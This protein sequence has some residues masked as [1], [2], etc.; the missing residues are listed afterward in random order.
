MSTE[1][2]H[3]PDKQGNTQWSDR[4]CLE[5]LDAV[6]RQGLSRGEAARAMSLF[7][8]RKVSRA[9]VIG[10]LYRIEQAHGK[11]PC[12]CSKPENQDGG[13]PSRWWAS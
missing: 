10:L 7:L 4:E 5:M 2:Q 11:V 6:H 9:T 13:M 3:A 1:T 12:V 8:G